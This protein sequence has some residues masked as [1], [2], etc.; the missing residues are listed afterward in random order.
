ML[1]H[2]MTLRAKRRTRAKPNMVA[3]SKDRSVLRAVLNMSPRESA[4]ADPGQRLAITTAHEALEMASFVPES[5][6]S[7]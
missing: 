3:L 1:Q 6:T 4:N 5:T 2:I 7:T